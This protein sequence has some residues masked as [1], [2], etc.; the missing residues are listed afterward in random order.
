MASLSLDGFDDL[1]DEIKRISGNTEEMCKDMAEAAADVTTD[2]WKEVI[3]ERD[4][5]ESGDM[6][7][8]VDWT[9]ADRDGSVIFSEVYPQGKDRKGVRNVEKAYMLHNGWKAG[10]A[11][12]NNKKSKGAKG[13]YKGDHFVDEAERRADL[14]VGDAMEYVMDQYVKED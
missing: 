9:D 13:A 6:R 2:A 7:D 12:K 4:H 5:V 11:S 10:K 14:M 3:E 1:N 8:S